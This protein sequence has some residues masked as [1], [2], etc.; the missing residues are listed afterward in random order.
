MQVICDGDD[1]TNARFS[2][3]AII[4][5][6]MECRSKSRDVNSSRYKYFFSDIQTPAFILIITRPPSPGPQ[7]RP[8]HRL[9]CLRHSQR[10]L[11]A[12]APRTSRLHIHC[13]THCLF[14]ILCSLLLVIE[15]DHVGVWSGGR[16]H[17]GLLAWGWK[18]K[19]AKTWYLMND[20][21]RRN[22]IGLLKSPFAASGKT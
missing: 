15:F 16:L 4:Y 14:V 10:P 21:K 19:V 6:S 9:A 13:R 20:K 1:W 3:V 17:G 22:Q 18:W 11:A 5:T 12:V 7:H 2:T 8:P